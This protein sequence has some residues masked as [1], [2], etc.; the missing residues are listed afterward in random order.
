MVQVKVA[1][2]DADVTEVCVAV[3][4]ADREDRRGVDFEGELAELAG[5]DVVL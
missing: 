5:D 1:G 2:L 3:I 4:A